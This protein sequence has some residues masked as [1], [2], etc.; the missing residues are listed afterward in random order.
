MDTAMGFVTGIC[1][2]TAVGRRSAQRK[3]STAE[4]L[5]TSTVK[6]RIQPQGCRMSPRTKPKHTSRRTN[7]GTATAK[8]NSQ[9]GGANR[10]TAAYQRGRATRDQSSDE[11][12]ASGGPHKACVAS[13]KVLW[14]VEV[15]AEPPSVPELPAEAPPAPALLLRPSCR[16][17]TERPVSVRTS[18]AQAAP[19]S[20]RASCVRSSSSTSLR[21]HCRRPSRGSGGPS[22]GLMTAPRERPPRTRGGGATLP[23]KRQTCPIAARKAWLESGSSRRRAEAKGLAPGPPPRARSSERS[24]C[25][26]PQ[27][28]TCRWPRPQCRQRPS[29]TAI[30][31]FGEP[32]SLVS[33]KRLCCM[34]RLRSASCVP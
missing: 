19:P 4:P 30:C 26:G 21:V 28:S 16:A 20:Q 23:G 5:T 34:K 25:S 15:L 17:N 22:K 8:S 31:T 2:S 3:R 7:L 33:T 10:A 9:S 18:R 29:G 13:E 12:A 32:G 11:P 24:I 6:P 27:M 1:E 14:D